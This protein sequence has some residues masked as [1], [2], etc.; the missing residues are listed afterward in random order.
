[1]TYT[2]EMKGK[3]LLASEN[4]ED[5]FVNPSLTLK[6]LKDF[7]EKYPNGVIEFG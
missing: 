5:E 1:M 4:D 6:R 7:Y 3:I 2:G